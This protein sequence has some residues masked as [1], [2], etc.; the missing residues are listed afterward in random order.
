MKINFK[1]Q[2]V[3]IFVLSDMIKVILKKHLS[4]TLEKYN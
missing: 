4:R 1:K 3:S 2:G